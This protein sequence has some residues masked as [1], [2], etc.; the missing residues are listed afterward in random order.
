MAP[1]STQDDDQ[2]FK[3]LAEASAKR[4]I[5]VVPPEQ[6]VR[7]TLA[8][9]SPFSCLLFGAFLV[10]ISRV[11]GPV[12]GMSENISKDCLILDDQMFHSPRKHVPEP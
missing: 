3:K 5:E 10:F 9:E 1:S 8:Q 7:R 2:R 11:E 12:Y 6:Q 4:Y